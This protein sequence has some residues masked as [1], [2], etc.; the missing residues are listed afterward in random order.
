M[1]L[2]S[3]IQQHTVYDLSYNL[4]ES[5]IFWPG[6]E[7]FKLCMDCCVDPVYGYDYAA[8]TF[9]T[10]E[11]G[12][13]HIDAPYHFCHSGKTVDQIPLSQLMGSCKVI[14]IQEECALQ[15]DYT[16]SVDN[17]LAFEHKYGLLTQEDIVLIRTGWC[18]KYSLGTK[19]YLG[20]DESIEGPYDSS[21]HMLSFPGISAEASQ[22]FVDR[23]I[24]GVGLDTASLDCG[25]SKNFES[26]QILLTSNIFGIENINEMILLLPVIGSMLIISPLKLVGGSG[27]PSRVMAFVPK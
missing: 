17:I 12:G 23:K 26:H 19:A 18:K 4:E 5:T 11:H 1:A 9:T 27:S 16:L 8:G 10:A 3:L 20:Y 25:K 15:S 22:L 6:G 13:T 14:D 24:K 7:G 2:C 21:I